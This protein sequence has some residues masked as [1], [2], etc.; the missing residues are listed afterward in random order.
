MTSQEI[1]P[2]ETEKRTKRMRWVV[3]ALLLLLAAAALAF[4][5]NK[6][7]QERESA[8][9]DLAKS[10]DE[11]ATPVVNVVHPALSATIQEIVLP[12]NTQPFI[13]SPIYART[14]GYL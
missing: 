9:S 10:T 8:S 5:I 11:A 3:P 7:I 13:D 4:G 14:N 12:G 2:P 1:T 6:G